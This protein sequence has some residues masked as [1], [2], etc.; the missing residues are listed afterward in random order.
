MAAT[1]RWRD[2]VTKNIDLAIQSLID[3][4][5]SDEKTTNITW[6]NWNLQKNFNENQHIQLNG[7]DVEYNYVKYSYDQ[8]N[9]GEISSE[10]RIIKREG[11]IIVYNDGS[12][13]NYI[14]DQNSSAM[15]LLRRLLSFSGKNEL[16]KNSF[17]FSNDF[18][19][20][21]IFRVYYS[22]YNVELTRDSKE[23]ELNSIKSIKGNT[24]DLQTTVSASGE[25]VMNIISTLSFLLESNNL[26]QIKL[27]LKYTGHSNISLLMQKG[28]VNAFIDDYCGLFDLE[29]TEQKVSKL[30]LTVYLE[31]LPL[32]IQEYGVDNYNA[33]WNREVY[34]SFMRDVRQTLTDKIQTKIVLLDME[35]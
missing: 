11:F 30:Y 35:K 16:E 27:D 2:T 28:I 31:I 8:T 3:K 25:T 24:D 14:I 4:V 23:L 19:I 15:K 22:N 7:K 21:L 20:W 9:T 34:I 18:F 10:N 13:I 33:L 29:E 17:N 12:G 26:N 1:T 5:V 32:L 6:D